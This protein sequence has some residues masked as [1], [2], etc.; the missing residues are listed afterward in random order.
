MIGVA[1]FGST[2]YLSQY[3][4]LARAMSPTQAG[5]MS[6]AMVGGLLVTTIVT[7]RVISATGYWKRYLVAGALLTTVGFALLAILLGWWSQTS[8]VRAGR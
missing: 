8:D 2:V 6:I 1:M 7:G 3:F 5:L 4:Q